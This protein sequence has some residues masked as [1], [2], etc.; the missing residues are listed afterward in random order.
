MLSLPPRKR[1]NEKKGRRSAVVVGID[2]QN[3]VLHKTK[4]FTT[5]RDTWTRCRGSLFSFFFLRFLTALTPRKMKKI[6]RERGAA[7]CRCWSS[8]GDDGHNCGHESRFK[9]FVV[10]TDGWGFHSE[11]SLTRGVQGYVLI[12]AST[13][14]LIKILLRNAI[15][16]V[17]SL[18]WFWSDSAAFFIVLVRLL[19]LGSAR[20]ITCFWRKKK[21]I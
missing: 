11:A 15:Y 4:Y 16:T 6:E 14:A 1:E 17:F 3:E 7:V 10:G 8:L 20:Y 9:H 18:G 19:A 12:C 2:A 21:N 5:T 13:T